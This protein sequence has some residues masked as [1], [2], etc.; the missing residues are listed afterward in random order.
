MNECISFHG[1]GACGVFNKMKDCGECSYYCPKEWAEIDGDAFDGD[2]IGNEIGDVIEEEEELEKQAE[3]KRLVSFDIPFR[4]KIRKE[5]LKERKLEIL[6]G[7]LK[8]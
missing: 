1:P 7:T 2:K 4:S 5:K 6:K 3:Q 8:V